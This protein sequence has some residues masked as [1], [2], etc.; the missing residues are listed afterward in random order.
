LSSQTVARRYAAALADV[1]IE[2]SEEREIQEELTEWHSMIQGNAHLLEVFS[3]PT[4]PYEQKRKL[5]AELIART[6]IRQTTANFLQILLKNQRLTA[7]GEI[8]QRLSQV[9]D[10]R[11]GV[12][13]AQVTSARNV[14]EDSKRALRAKLAQI[15]RKDVRLSF[16]TDEQLIGGLVTRIGSTVFDSSI[17]NQIRQLGEKMAGK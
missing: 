4:V 10:E 15:M 2:R 1:I 3:N 8:N 12:V 14:P 13:A 6:R 9:L 11:S 5:L 17:Q 7:L 16:I